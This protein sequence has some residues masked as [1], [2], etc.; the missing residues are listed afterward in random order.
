MKR[1]LAVGVI[2]I[3]G[4]AAACLQGE[5][6]HTLYLSPDGSVTWTIRDTD[7][8]SDEADPADRRREEAGYLD[9]VGRAARPAALALRRLSAEEVR[10]TLVRARRPYASTTEADFPQADRLAAAL[11]GEFGLRG[12]ADL[13][14]DGSTR[15]L[16]IDLEVPGDGAAVPG[17]VEVMLALVDDLA[18]YRLILTDGRFVAAQG[19]VLQDAT[20]AVLPPM[21]EGWTRLSLTW[22]AGGG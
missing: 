9:E 22:E 3:S 5:T 6:R 10:S 14:A 15:T 8:R 16:R 20:T 13:V 2:G 7:V 21:P 17:P 1:W 4:M 11:L 12:A 19:F 18:D